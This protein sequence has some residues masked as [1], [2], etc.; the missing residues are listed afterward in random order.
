MVM[1]F[2]TLTLFFL[3]LL[4]GS[5]KGERKTEFVSRKICLLSESIMP[6][7]SGEQ[8]SFLS[9]APNVTESD[10]FA[11]LQEVGYGGAASPKGVFCLHLTT[12]GSG[13]ENRSLEKCLDILV[14]DKSKLIWS[15]DFEISSEIF[16]NLESSS[17]LANLFL[18]SGPVFELDFDSTI[19]RAK[20]LFRF[21]FPGEEFLPRAPDPEEIIIGGDDDSANTDTGNEQHPEETSE[22]DPTKN[23]SESA[24]LSNVTEND[25]S[26]LSEEE[27]KEI[28]PES[29]VVQEE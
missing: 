21:L 5:L 9:L 20:N 2:S 27:K 17:K 22:I 8:L 29:D 12:K 18:T 13:E 23:E 7:E 14:P 4:A 6:S 15:I 28:T 10:D 25:A 19:E 1:L 3:L 11:F 26:A 24:E 16:A